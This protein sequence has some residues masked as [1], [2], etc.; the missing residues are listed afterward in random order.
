MKPSP[1]IRVIT[2]RQPQI[3]RLI[4]G[5]LDRVRRPITKFAQF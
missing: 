4:T 2:I 3:S 5:E 1:R